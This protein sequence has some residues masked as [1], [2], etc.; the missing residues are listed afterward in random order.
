M[1]S[2]SVPDVAIDAVEKQ[3]ESDDNDTDNEGSL[4][5]FNPRTHPLFR[6]SLV[7]LNKAST[8]P[9]YNKLLD[10]NLLEDVDNDNLLSYDPIQKWKTLNNLVNSN[11]NV[12]N[13]ADETDNIVT[14][15]DK[16]QRSHS[17]QEKDVNKNSIIDAAK[18]FTLPYKLQNFQNDIGPP[19][20]VEDNEPEVT[21]DSQTN[22]TDITNDDKEN[23][24]SSKAETQNT[25]DKEKFTNDLDKKSHRRK[26]NLSPDRE[27]TSKSKGPRALRR[28]HGKKMDK[29]RKLRRRSSI[30]GHWYDRDTSVFTPPKHTPMCVYTSS[31]MSPG[32]VITTLMDKYKIESSPADYALYVVKETGETRLVSPQE[33]PLVLRVNLGPHEVGV[34]SMKN[35]S[36]MDCNPQSFLLLVSVHL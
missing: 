12:H 28:R 5:Y 2:V 10:Q 11:E 31:K 3:E 17:V 14:N 26:Q 9:F 8:D 16:V 15:S 13:D 21:N 35:C 19:A 22:D 24:A 25:N 29:T 33:F 32:E 36:G 1:I 30:N 27:S 34:I 4:P 6:E 20:N 7:E 23:I 18:S